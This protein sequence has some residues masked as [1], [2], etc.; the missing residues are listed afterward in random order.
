MA[1]WACPPR[2]P[3]ECGASSR[4][5]PARCPPRRQGLGRGAG[6]TRGWPAAAAPAQPARGV[7]DAATRQRR[8]PRRRGR[9]GGAGGRGGDAEWRRRT[10]GAGVRLGFGGDRGARASGSRTPAAGFWPL[11]YM[12][13]AEKYG[14]MKF[15]WALGMAGAPYRAITGPPPLAAPLALAATL[16][17]EPAARPSAAGGCSLPPVRWERA[18]AHPPRPRVLSTSSTCWPFSMFYGW[19]RFRLFLRIRAR[20]EA[21]PTVWSSVR[22]YFVF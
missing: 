4:T 12:G 14:G 13:W 2:A 8:G 19:A 10:T 1:G 6:S 7:A 20:E 9:R 21:D 5:T 16:L 11:G 18:Q 22:Y 15:F 17:E 3:A